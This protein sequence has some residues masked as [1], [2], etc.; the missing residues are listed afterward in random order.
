MARETFLDELDWQSRSICARVVECASVSCD[1]E[2]CVEDWMTANQEQISA[3]SE[4][5]NEM[6]GSQ[7]QDYAMYSV[8]VR[9]LLEF[10]RDMAA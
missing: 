9:G 5:L 6:R 10:A 7:S 8:A 3:W 2:Q 1:A 4:M